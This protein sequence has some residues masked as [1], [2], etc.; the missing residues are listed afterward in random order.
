MKLYDSMSGGSRSDTCIWT[1]GR[2]RRN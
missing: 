2:I 1:D